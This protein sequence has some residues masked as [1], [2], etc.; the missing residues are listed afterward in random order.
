[1][2][3][4][5]GLAFYTPPLAARKTLTVT[6]FGQSDFLIDQSINEKVGLGGLKAS[7]GSPRTTGAGDVPLAKN[8][9]IHPFAPEALIKYEGQEHLY[10]NNE[11]LIR[12]LA[13]KY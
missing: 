3:C 8:S 12:K 7:R 2:I 9:K 1:M 6:P 10:L 13:K 11:L 4:A 5:E